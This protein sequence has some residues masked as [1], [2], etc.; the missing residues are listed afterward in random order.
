MWH[1]LHDSFLGPILVAV[2]IV[3]A[4]AAVTGYRLVRYM[5][6]SLTRLM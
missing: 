3:L 2:I 5:I 1:A 4:M 6:G